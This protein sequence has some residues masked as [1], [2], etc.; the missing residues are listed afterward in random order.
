GGVR[1]DGHRDP[2]IEALLLLN[3][4]RLRALPGDPGERFVLVDAA[5]S[6][7]WLYE[8]GQVMG[9]MKAISGSAHDQ[10]PQMGALIRY[11]IFNPVWNVPPDIA[12]RSYAARIGADRGVLQRLNMDVW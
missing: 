9:S 4:D 8:D 5:S 11:A 1:G 10:T 12:R 6:R 7:L 3:L 2:A